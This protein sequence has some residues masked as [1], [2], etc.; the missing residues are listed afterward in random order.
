MLQSVLVTQP[1]MMGLVKIITDNG[2][3][4]QECGE[5]DY[6]DSIEES[7]AVCIRSVKSK[8][9]RSAS[10]AQCAVGSI[11]NVLQE[12][13]ARCWGW[14]RLSPDL[15]SIPVYYASVFCHDNHCLCYLFLNKN[16]SIPPNPEFLEHHSCPGRQL[17]LIGHL[18]SHF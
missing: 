17:H 10:A 1:V 16:I 6:V 3:Q 9:V 11:P 18:T 14:E 8:Y 4:F 13:T 7:V 2:A 5:R 12:S 15:R